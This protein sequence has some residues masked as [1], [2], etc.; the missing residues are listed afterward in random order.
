[1]KPYPA[2][3]EEIFRHAEEE[4]ALNDLV[5]QLQKIIMRDWMYGYN[6]LYNETDYAVLKDRITELVSRNLPL[7]FLL[8]AFPVKSSNKKEKV[9]GEGADFA[10]FLALR[11]LITTIR[12]LQAIYKHGVSLTILSDYHT[13]D[14]FI[15]VSEEAYI[16]YHENLRQIIQQ[17][18]AE[19]IIELT[20]LAKFPEFKNV[21]AK[22]LSTALYERYG[23]EE[24]LLN[25]DDII[26][27]DTAELK[28]YKSLRRFMLTDLETCLPGSKSSNASKRF[29]KSVARGMMAQGVALN[30]FLSHQTTVVDFIR[31]S[32]HHHQPTTGKFAIDLFKG[33]T[34]LD[35][36]L[37]TPWHNVVI[38][39][40][41]QGKFLI[42]HKAEV[43]K[44]LAGNDDNDGD[45]SVLLKVK[46]DGHDWMYIRLGINGD[47]VKHFGSDKLGNKEAFRVSMRRG[48]CGMML[49]NE[50][51]VDDDGQPI[52]SNCIKTECVT[53]VLK[54]FGLVVLR[55]FKEFQDE[56]EMTEVY[57]RRAPQGL[58]E[59]HFGIL[60]KLK[61]D[62]T[63]KDVT[64]SYESLPVHFDMM[65]LPK[66]MD[67][68]QAKHQYHDYVCREF[69]LYCKKSC[70][71]GSNGQTTIIDAK[72][73][74]LALDG[75]KLQDWKKTLIAYQSYPTQQ[76][77]SY[78][79]GRR[80]V[81]QYP[82]IMQCP[83]TGNDVL[84]WHQ[85]WTVAEHPTTRQVTQHEW[86]CAPEEVT[87]S[88]LEEEVQ[89]IAFDERFYFGHS[90]EKGDQVY[91]NNY[92]VL[93]GRNGLS[94]DREL[95]RIQAVP[96]GQNLPTYFLE[97]SK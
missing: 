55:G 33:H 60:H 4:A 56:T 32:I 29:I 17:Q 30:N 89:R 39:D 25:F 1:M 71:N 13:F 3:T 63:T 21:P 62:E 51:V 95:W 31:L 83:W 81:Y 47:Y 85:R 87:S 24:F 16:K 41:A 74:A 69:L 9:L 36:K 48:G 5:D 92:T 42:G 76:K 82:L 68:D 75:K 72:A 6:T 73:I 52:S 66:Y 45:N 57:R 34:T 15:G 64:K 77:E 23:G 91:V 93:H 49:E 90:Y 54:E 19:D 70:G 20:S 14:Q 86:I 11:T 8:P 10:E 27:N 2:P 26:K 12:K 53:S 96:P 61:S 22:M 88:H 18:G 78:F 7:R 44:S 37:K 80:Q 40:S 38:F 94:S 97:H 28:K 50:L 35:G 58:F 79:G 59:W 84:R 46:L 65:F 43:E 67:I